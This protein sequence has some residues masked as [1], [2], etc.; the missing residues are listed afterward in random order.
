MYTSPRGYQ[1]GQQLDGLMTLLNFIQGDHQLRR[2]KIL[3]MVKAIGDTKTGNPSCQL[4][5]VPC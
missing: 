1:D 5:V 2:P 3:V 4:L